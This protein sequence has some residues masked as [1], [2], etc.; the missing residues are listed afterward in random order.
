MSDKAAAQEPPKPSIWPLVAMMMLTLWMCNRPAD[1]SATLKQCGNHLH[2]IGVELEKARL[3]SE[4][5][6]YPS[7]LEAAFGKNPIPVC[8]DGGKNTYAQGY[9]PSADGSS[10]L[11]VC[12]GDFHSKAGVPSDYPRIAF[13]P[14]EGVSQSPDVTPTAS[15]S[16][17][18]TANP[19]A[20]QSPKISVTPQVST[21]PQ[22]T[23][24]PK[25]SKAQEGQKAS[26]GTSP[27]PQATPANP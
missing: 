16:P 1:P 17:Q 22:A 27:S 23:P 11:L 18:A 19:Q 2:K 6:R 14:A 20:T 8:P 12:K 7:K 21:S 15:S 4:D 13:G 3:L 10:Y 25:G 9:Q 5:G 26:Q 24:N